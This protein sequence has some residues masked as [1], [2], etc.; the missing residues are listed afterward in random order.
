VALIGSSGV[1][2]SSII[3]ALLGSDRQY[4]SPKSHSTGKGRHTTS[5]RELVPLPQGGF[6]LDTPG[7]REVSLWAEEE[8]VAREFEQLE[9][10]ALQCRFSDCRHASEPDCAVKEAIAAGLLEDWVVAEYRRLTR[11]VR[12]LA[13]RRLERLRTLHRKGLEQPSHR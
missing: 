2:K 5:R 11:E 3:N 1:G 12:Y 13:L 6:L 10:L 4:V 9:T 8:D 7:M